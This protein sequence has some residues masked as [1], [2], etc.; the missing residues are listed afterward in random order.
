[1]EEVVQVGRTGALE[2]TEATAEVRNAD[3]LL[4]QA[5]RAAEPQR[6]A[7]D[8]YNLSIWNVQMLTALCTRRCAQSFHLWGTGPFPRATLLTVYERH[9][10]RVQIQ[11]VA[12]KKEKE[13]KITEDKSAKR[14]E[15]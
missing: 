6:Q 15:T 7:R 2:A 8:A 11:Q 12:D 14:E 9:L 1:M 13:E 3:G 4:V 10:H 5:A